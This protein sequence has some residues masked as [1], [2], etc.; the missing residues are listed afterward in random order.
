[1]LRETLATLPQKTGT[2]DCRLFEEAKKLEG[3]D[4]STFIDVM[5]NPN[6]STRKIHLALRS[7]GIRID[8]TGLSDQRQC[9]KTENCSCDWDSL[10]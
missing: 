8:R 6:I 7:E 1:M 10:V 5:L 2:G 4:R 9:M 3:E